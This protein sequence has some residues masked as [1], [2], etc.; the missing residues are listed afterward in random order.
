MTAQHVA[1]AAK[2]SGFARVSLK[3]NARVRA[4]VVIS[5]DGKTFFFFYSDN[6]TTS[7]ISSRK[8]S[9]ILIITRGDVSIFVCFVHPSESKHDRA[10]TM[11]RQQYKYF[12]LKDA[13]N[14][15]RNMCARKRKHT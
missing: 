7:E 3:F 10:K 13:R 14:N 11:T 1:S 5:F 2:K 8:L 6:K 15:K 12:F 4:K 9:F